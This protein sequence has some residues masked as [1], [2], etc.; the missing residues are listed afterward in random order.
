L[1]F[2][3]KVLD[4]VRDPIPS[5]KPGNVPKR[6]QSIGLFLGLSQCTRAMKPD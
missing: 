4:R 2:P 1:L 6:E 5:L 3:L